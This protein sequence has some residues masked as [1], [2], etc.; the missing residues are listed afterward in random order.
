MRALLLSGL[1][2]LAAL[3]LRAQPKPQSF[4]LPNGLRVIHLEDHEHALVRAHLYL[5]VDPDDLPRDRP[6]LQLLA[7]QMVEHSDA[8]NLKTDTLNQ[9]L[10]EAGIRLS[11]TAGADGLT[12]R[13]VARSRDQDQAFGLL[14]DRLLRPLFD[15]SV[16]ETQRLDCWRQEERQEEEAPVRLRR[17]LLQAPGTRPTLA[18]LSAI[19]WEDLLRFRAQVFR[20]DQAVLVL[21][22]DLGLEQAKRLVLLTLGSWT[23]PE[24]QPRP[25]ATSPSIPLPSPGSPRLPGLPGSGLRILAVAPPPPDVP[26]E[27]AAL[28][29]LLLAGHAGI[30]PV[31]IE[32]EQ[33]SLVAILDSEAGSSSS[34]VWPLLLERLESL[35]RRGFTTA[36]LDRARTAWTVGRSRVSLHPEAQMDRALADLLHPALTQER[37]AEVSLERLNADLRRWLDPANLRMGAAGPPALLNGL[38]TP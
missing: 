4:T 7:L 28:I 37:L 6:G 23:P 32:T 13:M 29:R 19:T 30:H 34:Q 3:T 25:E 9:L 2:G 12:W 22:G 10:E 1:V 15:P 17:A 14:A 27:C 36:D 20:P 24:A 5:K 31:R 38:P 26:R 8:A 16:L 35:R 21:H 33:G 11:A 18:S